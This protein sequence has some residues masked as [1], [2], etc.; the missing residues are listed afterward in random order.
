MNILRGVLE[1]CIFDKVTDA[2]Q[3][4]VSQNCIVR[5]NLVVNAHDD[6]IDLN[7]SD[8]I[9]V[10]NNRVFNSQD[11]GLSVSGIVRPIG[12]KG[13]SIYLTIWWPVVNLVLTRRKIPS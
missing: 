3:V 12:R 10:E 7:Q 1:N 4:N 8:N 13:V 11:K 2:I 6:A 5:N 9:Y